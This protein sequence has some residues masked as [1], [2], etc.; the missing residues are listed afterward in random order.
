MYK[1]PRSYG[2]IL[3][4]EED[5]KYVNDNLEEFLKLPK[6]SII[7]LSQ[8]IFKR[9]WF[10]IYGSNVFELCDYKNDYY[11]TCDVCEIENPIPIDAEWRC[12]FQ[13]K[14]ID[15]SKKGN[16]VITN[17]GLIFIDK[18]IR[19]IDTYWIYNHSM[20]GMSSTL[21]YQFL[22]DLRDTS[23]DEIIFLTLFCWF[24]FSCNGG[25]E[26]RD[27][28]INICKKFNIK[29][30]KDF[31]M[32]REKWNA[33][34]VIFSDSGSDRFTTYGFSIVSFLRNNE[35]HRD[36]IKKVIS[37]PTSYNS[38]CQDLYDSFP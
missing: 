20:Q 2:L 8:L 15:Y 36:I 17:I 5:E 25:A 26:W 1:S 10:M 18:I 33:R 37:I 35:I 11:E 38:Y 3:E 31:I 22:D 16:I 23:I 34:G 7:Y 32:L 9:K 19:D 30:P 28:Y 4:N 21:F 14:M 13:N 29:N 12:L 24:I 6:E 27:D